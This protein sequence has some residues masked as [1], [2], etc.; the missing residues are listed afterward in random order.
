MNQRAT[1]I[2]DLDGTLVDTAPDLLASLNAV[3]TRAG[4]R[5]VVPTELRNLVGHGVRRLF[6]RAFAETGEEVSPEQLTKYCEEFL[7]HYRA[8]IAR[9]SRPFPG[10]PE[11]LKRLADAGISLGVCT[12]KP[13]ELTE[14]LLSQLKLAHYFMVVIGSGRAAFNKPDARHIYEVIDGLKGERGH[15]VLV[16][17]S[18]VDVAAAR[19]A[20]IPVIVMSYGYTP[21]SVHEMGADQVLDDFADV[22]GTV[23]RM[24]DRKPALT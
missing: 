4:H 18:P 1:I 19:A 7:V 11:T 17:D 10:V 21:T 24:L 15:A 5:A 22:P 20:N 3:L 14:L 23:A 12:N 8:N 9:E 13:Q 2:F 16:G 6:E